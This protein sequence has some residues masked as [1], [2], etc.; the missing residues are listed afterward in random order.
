MQAVFLLASVAVIL[1]N[2]IADIMYYY[3]D[4]EGEGMN[5]GQMPPRLKRWIFIWTPLIWIVL[6]LILFPRTAPSSSGFANVMGGF[7]D[8][9]IASYPAWTL[10]LAAAALLVTGVLGLRSQKKSSRM[11]LIVLAMAVVAFIWAFA[12][13]GFTQFALGWA[14]KQ[15]LMAL[16]DGAS[17]P[18]RDACLVLGRRQSRASRPSWSGTHARSGV[19]IAPTGRGSWVSASCCSSLRWRSLRPSS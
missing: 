11:A 17:R 2:L 3:L 5:D 7:V 6:E 19:S 8:K 12:Q 9:R 13:M 16:S 1:C 4:P 10:W 15:L 18:G 14:W